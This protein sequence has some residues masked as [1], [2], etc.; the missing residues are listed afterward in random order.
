MLK[1]LQ[2]ADNAALRAARDHAL[3]VV[4]MLGKQFAEVQVCEYQVTALWF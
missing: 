4:A 2:A 3:K 1:D